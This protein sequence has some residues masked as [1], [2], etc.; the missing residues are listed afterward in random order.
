M[1]ESGFCHAG[2]E[3]P[4]GPA[5]LAVEALLNEA[6]K[7]RT[8]VRIV[9]RA[10]AGGHLDPYLLNLYTDAICAVFWGA[11]AIPTEPITFP[12][13]VDNLSEHINVGKLRSI[14]YTRRTRVPFW[15]PFSWPPKWVDSNMTCGEVTEVFGFGDVQVGTP[16]DI[17]P[18]SQ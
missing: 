6:G 5:H 7:K 15:W 9:L 18:S 2:P 10:V 4:K 8:Q 13:M 17:Y 12:V 3:I 14:P 16:V 11:S 1:S